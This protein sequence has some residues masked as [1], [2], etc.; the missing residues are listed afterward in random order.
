LHAA[1]RTGIAGH[2]RTIVLAKIREIGVPLHLADVKSWS[3]GHIEHIPPKTHL[4]IGD[5]G[6]P[7]LTRLVSIVK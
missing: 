7:G 6:C 2:Q 4:V 5:T 1:A 3:V